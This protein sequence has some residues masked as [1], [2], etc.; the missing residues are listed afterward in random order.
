MGRVRNSN[1]SRRRLNKAAIAGHRR[2][3]IKSAA[4]SDPAALHVAHQLDGAAAKVAASDDASRV[5][6]RRALEHNLAAPTGKP[7]ST[8]DPGIVN[9]P[10]QRALTLPGCQRD[11]YACVDGAAILN[12]GSQGWLGNPRTDQPIARQIHR[13]RIS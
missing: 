10:T 1:A 2:R 6:N 4:H 5:F 13:N 9:N 8:N 3:G 7:G 11:G 12:A